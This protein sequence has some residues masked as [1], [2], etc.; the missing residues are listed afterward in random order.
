RVGGYNVYIQ[1]FDKGALNSSGSDPGATGTTFNV[2]CN[3]LADDICADRTQCPN[4][5]DCQ[6]C[7]GLT[8]QET[9]TNYTINNCRIR[10]GVAKAALTVNAT[11]FDQSGNNF[12]NKNL[13][14]FTGDTFEYFSF[15]LGRDLLFLERAAVFYNSSARN[16]SSLN[17]GT[18]SIVRNASNEVVLR[19]VYEDGNAR[20]IKEMKMDNSTAIVVYKYFVENIGTGNIT[21]VTLRGYKDYDLQIGNNQET[22]DRA[23]SYRLSTGKKIE[24]V[25]KEARLNISR[26]AAYGQPFFVVQRDQSGNR[27]TG[28]YTP[29][30]FTFFD[31]GQVKANSTEVLPN[32]MILNQETITQTDIAQSYAIS[33]GT[34]L[35]GR[36][37]IQAEGTSDSD[38]PEEIAQQAAAFS[39]VFVADAAV[40]NASIK[41]N[42]TTQNKPLNLTADVSN[43][44]AQDKF[45]LTLAAYIT[46]ATNALFVNIN[47]TI[48]ITG[49][50]T[51]QDVQ[52][53]TT[54][55]DE[56]AEGLYTLEVR[57]YD[58]STLRDTSIYFFNVTP[59]GVLVIATP[60]NQTIFNSTNASYLI[61]VRNTGRNPDIF[62]LTII[63]VNNATTVKLNQ[64]I[65]P[66]IPPNQE[67]N[68]TLLVGNPTEGLFNVTIR[69][70]STDSPEIYD[71]DDTL[72]TILQVNFSLALF[73]HPRNLSIFNTTQANYTITVKNN[74]NQNISINLSV[75]N[76][77]GVST[78]RLNQTFI[79][80]SLP[81]SLHN[82]TLTVASP[83]AGTFNVS[84]NATS[85]NNTGVFAIVDTLTTVIAANFSIKL[86]ADPRNRTI[87]NIS[88]ATYVITV[89]N[90]GNQN[91]SVNLS[92]M[93]ISNAANVTLNQTFIRDILA[94]TQLNLSLSVSNPV[95]GT[96][97]VSI[98]ATSPN[99]SQVFSIVDT[100]TTIIVDD[101]PPDVV[102]VTAVP[103]PQV[104]FG[105]VNISAIV[106]DN[107]Q[108]DIV[109]LNLTKPDGSR[110]IV[111]MTCIASR[112]S[113]L[114]TDTAQEGF[115]L[116]R[117]FA[118]DTVNNINASEFTLFEVIS[119]NIIPNLMTASC[120]ERITLGES[121][122]CTTLVQGM[123]GSCMSGA[124]VN[125]MIFN[126]TFAQIANG[127]S[128]FVECG[129]YGMTFAPHDT[130]LFIASFNTTINSRDA[131]AT[132]TVSVSENRTIANIELIVAEI[133]RSTGS[134]VLRHVGGTEFIANEEGRVA[135]QFLNPAGDPIPVAT[136][137]STLF[138]PNNT[139]FTHRILS[140]LADGIYVSNF[141][142]PSTLGVYVTDSQCIQGGNNQFA[143]GTFHVATWAELIG[144]LNTTFFNSSNYGNHSLEEIV[145]LINNVSN[146]LNNQSADT[147]SLLRQQRDQLS[148]ILN[149]IRDNA[150]MTEEEVFLVTDSI[151][152]IN[153]IISSVEAGIVP[154]Q[155]AV[156]Q[157]EAVRDSMLKTLSGRA[158]L[159]TP[160]G[161]IQN[162]GKVLA[163]SIILSI[164]LI[165][166]VM[167]AKHAKQ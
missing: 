160:A 5:P 39:A 61:T 144:R 84:V 119:R 150:D 28:I 41:I 33:V 157:V 75:M 74:G 100:V 50:T 114:I 32:S 136:C 35:A 93:N 112:C 79:G 137:N 49:Q 120:T 95:N 162:N 51:L 72:T 126:S 94:G 27:N 109:L 138:Y 78:A 30:N 115:Y 58:G 46:N 16:L 48:N 145:T 82:L 31:V 10:V 19:F 9:A 24:L 53:G 68:F 128:S 13:T 102:N 154:P 142:V 80:F 99:S 21:D 140:H 156:E 2:T 45:N 161:I 15:F 151:N 127:T 67:R 122:S 164:I 123:N 90:N 34:L 23:E 69:A 97:N 121:F 139:F 77:S 110:Q 131:R 124:T 18:P 43:N 106:T 129:V 25:N 166:A 133:N 165:F 152:T 8:L 3:N 147:L 117:I 14:A 7:T 70:N 149:T 44:G 65:T 146:N 85:P 135:V 17:G 64:S 62:N 96:F 111:P 108:V 56:F 88:A 71:E 155:Q 47:R 159:M 113:A 57:L 4:D 130:G 76:I 104:V 11:R 116:A 89:R 101:R 83:T 87:F 158:A 163:L 29:A 86:L 26:S 148:D 63:N 1:A 38:D 107:N 54:T 98:N 91:V 59:A 20:L 22:R 153:R 141:T 40:R 36:S 134:P 103:N 6:A 81:G 92:V 118:N 167:E 105:T 66:Q 55:S 143:S 12:G 37:A 42:T 60:E 132:D 125:F 73:A 52:V